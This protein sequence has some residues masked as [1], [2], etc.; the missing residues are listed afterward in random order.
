MSGKGRRRE[1]K[2]DNP[3]RR[4]P[5]R[6]GSSVPV[7]RRN[8]RREGETKNAPASLLGGQKWTRWSECV[9][10]QMCHCLGKFPRLTLCRVETLSRSSASPQF[11][12]Y[13]LPLLLRHDAAPSFSRHNLRRIFSRGVSLGRTLLPAYILGYTASSFPYGS[14]FSFFSSPFFSLLP[15]TISLL[16]AGIWG[17]LL[18]ANARA[19]CP[20]FFTRACCALLQ[21]TPVRSFAFSFSFH[22][23]TAAPSCPPLCHASPMSHRIAPLSRIAPVASRLRHA[24]PSSRVTPSLRVAPLSRIAPSHASRLVTRRHRVCPSRAAS[25][26]RDTRFGPAA[27]M[28]EIV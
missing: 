25:P 22:S 20:P 9:T 15:L 23:L 24:L 12:P 13:Q 2:G 11:S 10:W 17:P 5:A 18:L 21:L 8:G 16:S 6:G 28:E 4:L 26:R 14:S 27:E 1:K 7:E 3:P 19:G